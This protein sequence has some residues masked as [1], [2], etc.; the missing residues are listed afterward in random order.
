[1]KEA[2]KIRQ[3][4]V[5]ID[6]LPEQFPTHRHAADFWEQLGRTVATFSFLE[7]IL[8]KA[9]FAFTATREYKEEEIEEAY[10]EWLP[11][12]KRALSDTL[13]SLAETYGKAV[14]DH[15]GPTIENVDDLVENIKKA[16]QIRNV[17]CHGSW[18]TPDKD[19]K[20]L[21]LFINKKGEKFE[22]SIDVEFLAQT[23]CH[24]AELACGVI[25]SV[26]LMGWQF[27]GSSGPGTPVW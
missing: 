22:T 18:R 1:M 17:L 8:G 11:K 27:P 15:S 14:R 13:S 19:G 2:L 26:T 10:S 21:C 25:N 5:D 7:E 3:S 23:Q 4:Y 24:V 6:S 12:L 9:I 20:S 16:S